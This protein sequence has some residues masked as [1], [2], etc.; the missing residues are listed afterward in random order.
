MFVT[1]P[2]VW[3]CFSQVREQAANDNRTPEQMV[4]DAQEMRR[5]AES[6][7]DNPSFARFVHAAM[8]E[9]Q[10]VMRAMKPQA[11]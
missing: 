4:R 5:W 6:R 10:R 3:R 2:M 11:V 7:A 8:V 1:D 9:H